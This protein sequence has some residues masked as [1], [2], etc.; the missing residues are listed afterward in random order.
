MGDKRKK[1][2]IALGA[3]SSRG[4]A[5]IGVLQVLVE[6]E[7]P[8]DYIAGCSMG[9][10]IGVIYAA[11][12]ETHM[13]G[14][15]ACNMRLDQLLD[16]RVPRQGFIRG[17]RIYSLLRLLT[18]QKNLEDLDI[19]T[20]VV[21]TNIET[22]E[23]VILKEGNAADAVRASISIPGVFGPHRIDDALL[24]DGA[25]LERLPSGVVRQM[26]ADVVVG[27]N[28]T[29]TFRD[30]VSKN[31]VGNV[32]EIIAQTTDI[33]GKELFQI[34][35][36]PADIILLPPVWDIGS[37]ELERAEEA[38]EAGRQATLQALSDIK[39]LLGIS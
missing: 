12:A 15:L 17:E 21:A 8:I 34:K 30:L 39:R 19:P 2:G 4:L 23:L 26:G 5:H 3:G 9:A 24:V 33:M 25:V 37:A 16:I 1:L 18:K 20:Q 27:V 11:G 22:G 31:P 32:I 36:N 35:E 14:E 28:V 6:H 13:L 7:V 10:V 38:I 29:A